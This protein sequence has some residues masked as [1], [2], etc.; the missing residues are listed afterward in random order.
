MRRFLHILIT[1][2]FLT[3]VSNAQII[4]GYDTVCINS[5]LE[6]TTTVSGAS[7][8]YWGFCSAYLNNIPQGS[9]IAAGTGLDQP[10]SI[11]M[12]KDGNNFYVFCFNQG[13][14]N[15]MIR[16]DFGTAL[17]NAPIASN[18]GDFGGIVGQN[19]KGLW[20]VQDK[21]N[22]YAFLAAGNGPGNSQIVRFDFGA[23]L[24]NIP[25]PTDLGSLGGQIINPQDLYI[26]NEAGNWYGI[27][28][29][30]FTGNVKRLEFGSNL[31][32]IPTVFNLGNIGFTLS[33]PTGFWPITDGTDWFIFAVNAGTNS[34]TRI[35]FGASLVNNAPAAT[36][37]GN[38][39]LV[40]NS[41]RD[42]SII[43]DCDDWYGYVTDEPGNKDR[44]SVV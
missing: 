20:F 40:F 3:S 1:M 5:P 23:S 36:N 30:G 2:L 16:Y 17:S 27:T 18:L 31:N 7:S 6:L 42:I 19:P 37:L 28:M 26:F 35:D 21:G 38:F 32:S 43:R 29:E 15:E 24:A 44:K 22:W 8:Y 4:Q 11:A 9:S 39:N 12:A 14:N 25:V 10:T 41:P 33:F 13:G 34:V